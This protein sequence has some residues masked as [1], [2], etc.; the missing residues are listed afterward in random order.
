VD[1][2]AITLAALDV[3]DELGFEGFTMRAVATRLDV[4]V[5]GLYYHFPDKAQLIQAMTDEL[6][7]RMTASDPEGDWHTQAVAQCRQMRHA[8]LAIRDGARLLVTGPFVG[9]SV[10]L[11]V[12]E[13]LL[14]I[15]ASGVEDDRLGI[16]GETLVGYI[17]GYVLQEQASAAIGPEPL[18]ESISPVEHP[19]IVQQYGSIPADDRFTSA[20]EAIIAGFEK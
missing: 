20:I 1:A 5:G 3:L 16:A 18:L 7:S 4:Q 10:A 8:M 14:T 11:Q 19:T 9:S 12:F 17:I 13:H 6:C 15:L 2:R